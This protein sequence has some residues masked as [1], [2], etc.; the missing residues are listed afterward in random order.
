MN[1]REAAALRHN[2]EKARAEVK[3]IRQKINQD[4]DKKR[5]QVAADCLA[6]CQKITDWNV[7][8]GLQA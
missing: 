2:E 1:R 5:R 6:W 4:R 7:R 3:A 8:R